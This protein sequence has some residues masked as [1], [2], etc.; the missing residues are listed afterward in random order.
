[1]GKFFYI[2]YNLNAEKE[3]NDYIVQFHLTEVNKKRPENLH[4]Q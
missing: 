4:V 2:D 1:M 3:T